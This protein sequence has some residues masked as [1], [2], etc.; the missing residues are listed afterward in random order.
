MELVEVS[1]GIVGRSTAG[2]IQNCTFKGNVKGASYVGGIVGFIQGDDIQQVYKCTNYGNIEAE[3]NGSGGIIGLAR[4]TYVTNCSNF[5]YIKADDGNAGGILGEVGYSVKIYNCFNIGNIYSNKS[6]GGI[7]ASIYWGIVIS[8]NYNIGKI[9]GKVNY[10]ISNK[11]GG[12][13]DSQNN[14]FLEGSG[15][16][17]NWDSLNEKNKEYMQSQEF[18]DDLNKYIDENQIEGI[19]LL[20]W[21][22]NEGNYPTFE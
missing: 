9:E 5:G 4:T 18:V 3:D 1:D 12:N 15:Q 8:N 13:D 20:K 2:E 11:P 16:K 19:T 22:Y 6:A 10:A 21:K 17:G 7:T 14:F